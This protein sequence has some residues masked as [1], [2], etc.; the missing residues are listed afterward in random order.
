L[1]NIINI[2]QDDLPKRLIN[3][4][5]GFEAK[6]NRLGPIIGA[7]QM[8]CSIVEVPPGKK[9]WPKH[10][11][12]VNEEMFLILSGDA[13][14]HYGNEST[15]VREG[16]IISC[17]ANIEVAHQIENTGDTPLKYLA[18]GTQK[19]PEICHYPDSDKYGIYDNRN[20]DEKPDI[21]MLMRKNDSLDYYDGE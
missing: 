8:G 16:D 12:S 9:A 1:K 13:T 15:G 10:S 2:D 18:L 11:H 5:K 14:L 7:L 21:F 19:E 17:P 20:D 6:V 4:P 3:N